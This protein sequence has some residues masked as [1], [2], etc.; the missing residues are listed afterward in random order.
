LLFHSRLLKSIF[1]TALLLLVILPGI[2]LSAVK[3]APAYADSLPDLIVQEI[4][5]SPAEPAIDDTVT[6]TVT[7]KNQG[8]ASSGQNYLVCYADNNIL[9]TL[10]V[11]PL[12]AGTMTTLAFTWRADAGTHVIKATVDSTDLIPESSET[13]NSKTYTLTSKAADLTIQ[14]ITWSPSNPS[15]SDTVVFSIVIKNQG[16]AASRKTNVDFYINGASRSPQDLLAINP[17]GTTTVTYSWVAVFGRHTVKAVVDELTAVKE[18]NET[19]NEYS[20]TCQTA[21]PDLVIDKINWWPLNLSKNDTVSMNATVKNQGSG[22]SDAC[23][24]AY[25]IDGEMKTTLPVMALEAGASVTI[26][27]DWTILSDQHQVRVV[28]DSLQSVQESDE[29]NNEKSVTVSSLIPDLA[30]TSITWTPIDAAVGDAVTVTATIK[31]YGG[32]RSEKT[33]AICYIDGSAY[34]SLDIP[35]IAA[36]G[37]WKPSISWV[38]TG[39]SHA[40]SFAIDPD[41]TITEITKDN[42][43][44]T[45]N[46]NIVP[47]DLVIP[48]IIWSP[49]NFAI[50]DAVSF[51]VTVQN[52]GGGRAD[53]VSIRTYMD[54]ELLGTDTI[55]RI[56]AGSSGVKTF[57][58]KALNGRHTFR[59]VINDTRFVIEGDYSNNEN[60]V[61]VS[62]NMPD[63]FVDTV[64]WSPAEIKAGNETTF[65]ISIKNLG[66]LTAGPSRVACYI[67]GAVAGYTDIGQLDPGAAVSVHFIWNALAGQHTINIVADS[68]N[69]V[70]ELD[71]ANNTRVVSIPF[72]D[73]TVTDLKWLPADASAGDNV[74]FSA[75]VK[76]QGGSRSQAGQIALYIDG[77][78]FT[79]KDLPEIDNGAS[80]TSTFSWAAV[81]GKHKI[82]ITADSTN[83]V[84]ESD[85]TNNTKEADFSS[86]TPDLTIPSI[87]WLMGNP[88]TDDRVDV[89][90]NVKN[91][92]TGNAGASR[93]WYIV[94]NAPGIAVNLA[95]LPSGSTSNVSFSSYMKAGSHSV[96]ATIDSSYKI[97][98]LDETNN[99]KVLVF[100]TLVPDLNI[101]TLSI[102]PAT[103]IP[104]DNVTITVKVEN[105]GREKAT[106]FKLSLTIDGSQ[107]GSTDIKEL[108]MGNI[109]SQD[110]A[111]K[112]VLGSH[113][114]VATADPANSVIESNETN[115]SRSRSIKI[116]NPAPATATIKPKISSS[117]SANKG[118]LDNSWWIIL[119]AAGLLGGGAF[120]T[121]IKQAKKD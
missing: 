77:F 14:S 61:I 94:D 66:T 90:I 12:L 108:G 34:T 30:I 56:D 79:S 103:A 78:Q 49:F 120:Y 65:D 16:N 91:Q 47:P 24:L 101:T 64:T 115:N 102:A 110:F 40:V 21:P 60:S 84:T 96:N 109:A 121:V 119:L 41:N 19:N 106:N 97:A 54:G 74:T 29:T 72:P 35:E 42:N 55:D 26:T 5:L 27:Y 89:I 4:T 57:T 39:G 45:V 63:L 76:N 51:N 117:A 88:L 7:V 33:R 50:D 18:S 11:N 6:V 75:S 83:R 1:V 38:A 82:K 10:Q 85:E 100:T 69:K 3:S 93:L 105:R 43:R 99:N 28:V 71:E 114:I 81:A 73:L 104:G 32:G 95:A 9:G 20:A 46:I 87:S 58:W 23:Q 44:L 8:A 53:T 36:S 98:E 2:S 112:A 48:T 92:G 31:N 15:R 118:F 67:D 13:N 68:L 111:W 107:I 25:Y 116:E 52:I 37:V 113:E 17:G 86:L 59:A 22:R 80:V 70:A 62:P